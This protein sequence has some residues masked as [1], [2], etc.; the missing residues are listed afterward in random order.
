MKKVTLLFMLLLSVGSMMAQRANETVYLKN[1]SAIR[2]EVIEQVPG[3]SL[4][5]QTKDGSI[6][7][8]KME[9]V[10]RITKE[11]NSVTTSSPKYD[12]GHKGLDYSIDGGIMVGRGG[13][14]S[15]MGGIEVG[16][17]FN[18]NL[19][20][21]AGISAGGIGGNFMLPITTTVKG[22]FPVTGN[23]IAP[24]VAF[25]TS[26][27]ADMEGSS[28]P[29]HGL[30][31]AL[32]P[33]IQIPI[34]Q[35][36]DFNLNLGYVCTV[37]FSGG[38]GHAFMVSAGMGFHKPWEKHRHQRKE[39]PTRTK[40]MQLA[41]DFT[42]MMGGNFDG[43]AFGVDLLVGYKMNPNIS[44]ALGYNH[45]FATFDRIA[46]SHLNKIY[47]NGKY[48]LT[49]KKI[50]PLASVNIGYRGSSKDDYK[51]QFMFTPAIGASMR[52]AGN[53]YLEVIAG[54][55]LC[56]GKIKAKD[57]FGKYEKYGMSAFALSVG[58]TYTLKFLSK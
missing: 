54:Y 25:R 42:P 23:G 49:D 37:G 8:Y 20:W 30:M 3:Q 15:G 51:G 47:L 27:L 12:H 31:F 33:G 28:S 39:I 36:V 6:F 32:L 52:F 5:I 29:N 7:V 18:K 4:K 56:P 16:K 26:F 58:Y 48:R 17:R 38:A 40:G 19:Y 22:L 35:I 24:N 46:D 57:G 21:G 34:G 11:E 43:A 13:Y 10:E 55:E 1:G 14:V 41:I 45:T 9:E 2:G 44:F 53:S 50:S